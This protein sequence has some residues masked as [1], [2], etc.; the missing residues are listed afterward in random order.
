[1]H[2][3]IYIVIQK[4]PFKVVT[5]ETKT[6]LATYLGVHR[7]TIDN[8]F[9]KNDYWECKKGVVYKSDKHQSRKKGGNKDSF[10]TKEAKRNGDWI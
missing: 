10:A 3:K 1:M 5:F 2:K 6:D 7:N 9:N 8:K 4:E